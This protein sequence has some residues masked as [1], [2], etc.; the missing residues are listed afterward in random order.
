MEAVEA[1]E[2]SAAGTKGSGLALLVTSWCEALEEL[3][4]KSCSK[5][6]NAGIKSTAVCLL[7]GNY[8]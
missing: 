5:H 6:K 7:K 1:L 3:S 4:P 2:R 8:C